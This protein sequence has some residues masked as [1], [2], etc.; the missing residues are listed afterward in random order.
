VKLDEVLALRPANGDAATFRAAI[1]R[2]EAH[3]AR[4]LTEADRSEDIAVGGLLSVDDKT[5]QRAAAEAAQARLAAA[6]I[7]ALLPMIRQDHEAAAAQETVAGLRAKAQE[8]TKSA[9]HL[10]AWQDQQFPEIQ[11]LLTAGIMLEGATKIMRLDL[12]AAI[13]E[14]Y[15]NQAVRD[16]GRLNV[17]FPEVQKRSPFRIF[18]IILGAE[19]LS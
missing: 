5:L 2:A 7:D 4:L 9:A 10:Q 6:R 13:D 3:R 12:E 16:I 15:L 17:T 14:A 11:K 8:L 1:D 19:A 18:A